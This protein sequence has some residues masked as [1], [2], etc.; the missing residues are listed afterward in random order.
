[1]ALNVW[2]MA[3]VV[4]GFLGSVW[5]V[6]RWVKERLFNFID[7][8]IPCIARFSWI[9]AVEA[10]IS[11]TDGTVLRGAGGLWKQKDGTL[12]ADIGLRIALRRRYEEEATKV[13]QSTKGDE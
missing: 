5:W 8:N 13:I 4:I 11:L 2:L 12:V 10:E 9:D 7:R 1:M 6:L 3:I